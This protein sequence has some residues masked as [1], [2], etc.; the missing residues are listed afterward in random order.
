MKTTRNEL[1]SPKEQEILETLWLT[2]EPMTR[3]EI[4]AA[5]N[6]RSWSDSYFSPLVNGLLAKGY[7]QVV[8]RR[9]DGNILSR[10]FAPLISPE[11]FAGTQLKNTFSFRRKKEKALPEIISFLTASGGVKAQDVIPALETLL[12]QYKNDG[13]TQ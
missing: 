5:C 8:G 2:G 12:A 6:P 4:L 1:I 13:K 10:I 11:E 3:R 9:Q 7:L